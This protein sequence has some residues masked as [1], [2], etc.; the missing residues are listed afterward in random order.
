MRNKIWFRLFLCTIFLLSTL[1]FSSCEKSNEKSASIIPEE[2]TIVVVN[3]KKISL[4]QFQKQLNIFLKQYS[5][6]ITIDEKQ[7]GDIKKIVIQRMIDEEIIHQEAARKGINVSDAELKKFILISMTPSKESDFSLY[8]KGSI[9]TKEEWEKRLKKYLIEKRLVQKEVVDKIPIT[10][11]EI[12]SYYQRHRSDFTEPSAFRVRNITLPTMEEA[13]AIRNQIIRGKNF[14]FLVRKH[15][16]SP[17]KSKDGDLGYVKRGDLPLEMENAIFQL[18]F[19]KNKSRVS[20]VVRSQ[21]G[22]HVFKLEKYRKKHRR[23]LNQVKQEIK[24]ILIKQKWDKAYQKWLERLKSNAT[25]SI[26]QTMLTRE[27]GF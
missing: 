20:E 6:F 8:L 19:R 7:L 3:N 5:Q 15:S 9:M 11:R 26:D 4:S 10:K 16:I 17:D 24:K 2:E 18:G 12:S 27:Q 21:N 22:F 13:E 1:L 14:R 25:I 23:S